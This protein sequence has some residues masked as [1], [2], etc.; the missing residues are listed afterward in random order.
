MKLAGN[1]IDYDSPKFKAIFMRL[2]PLM[3]TLASRILKDEA[4]AKDVVQEVFVKL[5]QHT[6]ESFS[7][8]RALRSYLYVLVKNTCLNTIRKNSKTTNTLLQ[9]DTL[10]MERIC[11]DEIIKEETYFLL[12]SAI[13]SLSPQAAEVIKLSL[14][15]YTNEDIA[16][17][18]GVTLNT[19]KT[20]KKRAYNSLRH[21]LGD[22][23]FY[24]FLIYFVKF[25]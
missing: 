7:D 16:N 11:L 1:D 20:V 2:F 13:E 6:Q 10:I 19:V 24:T 21:T 15:G 8:E 12:N 5:C 3:C 18:L 23:L 9:E 25:L 22:Y 17:K 4:E 14:K